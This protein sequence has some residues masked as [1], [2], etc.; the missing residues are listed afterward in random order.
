MII[1]IFCVLLSLSLFSCTKK[2]DYISAPPPPPNNNGTGVPCPSHKVAS[3]FNFR[4]GKWIDITNPADP[5]P[6]WERDTLEFL[7]DSLISIHYGTDSYPIICPSYFNCR[8]F[9]WFER[10]YVT[11]DTVRH[12]VYSSYDTLN[13]LFYLHYSNGANKFMKVQ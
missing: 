11:N 10:Q 6:S 7:S 4:K 2:A 3:D 5:N 9:I 12:E 1:R 13:N 8:L